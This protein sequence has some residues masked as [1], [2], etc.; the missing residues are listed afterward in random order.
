MNRLYFDC[1]VICIVLFIISI[2]YMSAKLSIY[3]FFHAEVKYLQILFFKV[4]INLSVTP[5]F[6]SFCV[7]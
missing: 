2:N 6:P 1:A 5:D 7:E 4:L 3:T